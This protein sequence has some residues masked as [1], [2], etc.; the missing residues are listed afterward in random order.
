MKETYFKCNSKLGRF[1]YNDNYP[2]KN[3]QILINKTLD[4]IKWM[5]F[6]ETQKES[7]VIMQGRGVVVLDSGEIHM[8]EWNQAEMNGR[9]RLIYNSGD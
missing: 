3:T 2:L 8:G 7:K 6:G 9:G 4:G 5:Y 1:N